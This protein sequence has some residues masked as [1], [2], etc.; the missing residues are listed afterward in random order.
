MPDPSFNG[1]SRTEWELVR[2]GCVRRNEG[3][4]QK[5]H[6]K[7]RSAEYTVMPKHSRFR[8]L[9]P[10]Q[11][12]P[13]QARSERAG[14]ESSR[15]EPS[16]P[17]QS[18]AKGSTYALADSPRRRSHQAR[19]EEARGHRSEQRTIDSWMDLA[20][21]IEE[22]ASQRTN[23]IFRGEPSTTFELR[24]ASGRQDDLTSRARTVSYDLEDERAAL[25][26]FRYD[27]RPFA[28]FSPESSL[29]WLAIAQHHG[30]ATRL[31]DW[32]ESLLVAAFFAVERAGDEGEASIY[33]VSGLP[34]V[35][36]NDPPDPFELQ[37]VSIYRPRRVDM[38][39]AAQH[40]V[41]TIHPRPTE[42]FAHEQLNRWTVSKEACRTLKVTL[43]SC[44]VNYA[45]MFPDLQGLA[46]HI[47]WRY[48][49]GMSQGYV[50]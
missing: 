5:V 2:W 45:T 9:Q 1:W 16:R 18:G 50:S 39:I 29:E 25:R 34:L 11:L 6:I 48:K 44:G 49:W 22:L 32:T 38:R 24:P 13:T 4:R 19:S 21:L 27:A 37:E 36:M 28:G 12:Q 20:S 3:Y 42:P 40:S 15:R 35:D 17:K 14:E 8:R 26:R 46:R 10:K 43:D 23:W 30:M 31:L 41:F 47:D 33:G 7:A